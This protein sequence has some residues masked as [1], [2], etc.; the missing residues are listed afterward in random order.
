MRDDRGGARACGIA[1]ALGFALV[2]SSCGGSTSSASRRSTSTARSIRSSTLSAADAA[3]G[4][5]VA[6]YNAM[7]R[8]MAVAAAT[9]DYQSPQL[10]QHAAGN[11][12]SLLVR[13]LYTNLRMGVVV[14]GQPVTHPTVASLTP[15]SEPTSAA[16]SDCFDDTNSLNYKA[17]TGELQNNVPG[18]RHQTT[19]TVKETNGAWKVT[20]LQVGAVGTC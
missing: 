9:A 14:K 3:R 4:R 13:G 17:T 11:A 16:I 8:D 6:T 5:V 12:L 7:W 19:A 10:A 20:E 15:T 2:I 1:L 18:G